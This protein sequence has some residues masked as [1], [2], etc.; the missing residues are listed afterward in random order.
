[1]N[2]SIMDTHA[3]R[4]C[5]SVEKTCVLLISCNTDKTVNLIKNKYYKT[6]NFMPLP[7]A[8]RMEGT[9]AST[10]PSTSDRTPEL[11]DLMGIQWKARQCSLSPLDERAMGPPSP[12][13]TGSGQQTHNPG[14]L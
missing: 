4:K 13:T 7:C 1:M 10:D 3:G 6:E 11:G 9:S 5:K 12:L 2:T 8:L 14:L